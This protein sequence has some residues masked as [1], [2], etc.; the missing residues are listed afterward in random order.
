MRALAWMM[1]WLVIG[2]APAA[3]QESEVAPPPDVADVFAAPAEDGPEPATPEVA[4]PT[5]A[6]CPDGLECR[7]G[8]DGVVRAY[9]RRRE[10]RQGTDLILIGS[11]MLGGAWL[12]NLGASIP[13]SIL[14]G[15]DTTSGTRSTDYLGWG[16]VPVIGPVAQMF[17]LGDE[18]WAITLLALTEAIEIIG[19]VIAALG[20]VGDDV[21]L[22][23]PVASIRVS[24]W[25]TSE[26]AGLTAH[27]TF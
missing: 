2:A 11:V 13:G 1:G 25:A 6:R 7:R 15:Q 9:R 16:F 27:G 5:E 24:P 18:H 14:L 23:E 26:G 3:A 8:R 19:I 17:Q 20:T 21:T 22:L 12:A 4:P 10:H